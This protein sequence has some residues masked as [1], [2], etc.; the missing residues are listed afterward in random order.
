MK[1]IGFFYIPSREG[2]KLYHMPVFQIAESKVHLNKRYNLS[3]LKYFPCDMN[4]I[5]LS[6][7]SRKKGFTFVNMRTLLL[8]EILQMEQ[9]NQVAMSVCLSFF[10]F[11]DCLYTP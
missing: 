2:Y 11:L 10:C 8:S 9:A 5:L 3:T 6:I 4:N 1:S 7:V